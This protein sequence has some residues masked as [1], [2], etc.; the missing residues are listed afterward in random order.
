MN[1]EFP[2]SSQRAAVA[3]QLVEDNY[4]KKAVSRITSNWKSPMPNPSNGLSNAKQLYKDFNG[5]SPAR[6]ET[7]EVNIPNNWVRLGEGGVWSIGY[8]SGKETGDSSQ[9]YIHNFNED[10]KDGNFPDLYAATNDDG[11]VEMLI[12][13]GGS[14]KVESRPDG[15][16]WLVD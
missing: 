16:K 14:M 10:S 8:M 9:K 11:T 4:G 5:T 6:I 3:L 1:N 2:K 7:T 13:K 15:L 12:I